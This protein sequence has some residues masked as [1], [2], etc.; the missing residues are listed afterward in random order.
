MPSPT[1][2]ITPPRVPIVDSETGFVTREWYQ[3]FLTLFRLTGNG[4]NTTSLSD[5]QLGPGAN[6]F[7][8]SAV[9][10]PENIQ[11]NLESYL[12]TPQDN[13]Q[14]NFESYLPVPEDN[15]LPLAS[16]E[17]QAQ[18]SSLK[19]ELEAL[20][21]VPPNP[22][23]V[24]LHYASFHDTTTQNA[25]AI[26]TA[27]AITIN[28]T[29]LA[30]GIR[31]GSPTS[32]V[33]VNDAGVYNFQFSLQATTTGASSQYMYVWARVNGTDVPDSAGRVEF[34]GAGNDQVVAWNYVLQMAANDY[35]ELMWSVNDTNI[36]IV[37]LATIA[38]A[39]AIPSVILTVCEVTI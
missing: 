36:N 34:R 29:D 14:P 2:L 30:E 38:P 31:I 24:G 37:S 32:R 1:S 9:V 27:Y 35:F 8:Q 20:A 3:F 13:V 7:E 19:N 15:V 10:V 5:L 17:V 33:I 16:T 18:I 12:P 22:T 6:Y 28:T 26:N 25:A 39:P 4:Q 11:P 23:P 21:L